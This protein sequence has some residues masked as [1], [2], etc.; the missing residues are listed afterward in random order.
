MR[1]EIV[2][3]RKSRRVLDEETVPVV[4]LRTSTTSITSSH[5]N[6]NSCRFWGELDAELC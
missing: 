3:I 6:P 4:P 5:P 2:A 1:S